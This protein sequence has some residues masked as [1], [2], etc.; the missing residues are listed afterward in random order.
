VV[1]LTLCRP[2]IIAYLSMSSS[3][4]LWVDPVIQSE[5][6]QCLF[7]PLTFIRWFFR[8]FTTNYW[9]AI[10]IALASPPP[11]VS[12]SLSKQ[13]NITKWPSY[14]FCG[15]YFAF[16][17]KRKH[18]WR[19]T[20]LHFRCPCQQCVILTSPKYK[21]NNNDDDD[22]L[23]SCQRVKKKCERILRPFIYRDQFNFCSSLNSKRKR[24][25]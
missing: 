9:A 7:C 11:P 12:W 4:G 25:Q 8:W 21:G 19:S 22:F 24:V 18:W 14:A 13:Q 6:V 5:R 2:I 15:V 16:V 1:S 10:F 20:A 3:I 17:K 23:I